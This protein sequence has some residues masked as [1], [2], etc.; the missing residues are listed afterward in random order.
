M[1]VLFLWGTLAVVRAAAI[2]RLVELL[3][4]YEQWQGTKLELDERIPKWD[5]WLESELHDR[6]SKLTASS[7]GLIKGPVLCVGARLGGEVR[8]FRR[9]Q[10]GLLAIGIDFNPGRRNPYVLWGDAHQLEFQ[11]E[12]FGTVYVNILDHILNISIFADEAKRVLKPH[13]VFLIDMDQNPMDEYAVHNLRH[14]HYNILKVL[15]RRFQ[16]VKS[17]LV[18]DERDSPNYFH[19]LRKLEAVGL[20]PSYRGLPNNTHP[21]FKSRRLR[22]REP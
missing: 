15:T 10:P 17:F 20:S 13:G 9:I 5:R 2:Q 22:A 4:H 1:L 18:L 3:P 7:P 19:I 11:P 21:F 6:L 16:L 12:T 8:A 14:E